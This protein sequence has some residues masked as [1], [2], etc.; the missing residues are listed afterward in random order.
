MVECAFDILDGEFFFFFFR[1]PYRNLIRNFRESI[2][3]QSVINLN[4]FGLAFG[5]SVTFDGIIN[6]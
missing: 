6:S 4:R 1:F 5:E 3:F 2:V